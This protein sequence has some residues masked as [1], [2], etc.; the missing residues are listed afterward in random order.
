MKWLKNTTWTS[1]MVLVLS[2]SAWG[3]GMTRGIMSPPSNVRPPGLQNVGIEQHLDEQVPPNLTFR[4]ET[5][6]AVR[7][8]DYFGKRPM[9]LNLVY[10]QCPMLCG[11]VLSGLES[12]LRVLKFDVGKEFDVLTVSFDP[13]ETSEMASAKKAEYLKRYGRSGAA[14]GWHFLTGPQE[15]IDA[16]TTAAG[17]Q[18]QYDART[19]QFA[20]ATALMV[21]TPEG[22]IAQYFYGVEYAPKDL[23][24]ALVQASE[25][26]IGTVVDQVLLYCYHYD[27]ATGKY[28]AII[29]RVLQISAAATILVLSILI[30][31]LFRRGS[32]LS[33]QGAHRVT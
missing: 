3:Q 32:A 22:K 8:G 19:G 28:G 24:L 18:Y 9:I 25:K 26:K 13:H 33:G 4:D 21:L 14:A 5:G 2:I 12:G 1:A 30:A 10:Y 27:P 29:S 6:R 7:L 15:S 11:E 31:V 20:H 17:F 23:R 16:L